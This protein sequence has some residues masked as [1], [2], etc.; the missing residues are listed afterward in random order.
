[1]L[2]NVLM[3]VYSGTAPP[4]T[5]VPNCLNGTSLPSMVNDCVSN[6]SALT[7]N[8]RFLKPFSD[9]LGKFGSNGS[10]LTYGVKLMPT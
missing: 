4:N 6:N 1:M 9:P 8:I 2:G 10:V 3:P 5:P 7:S